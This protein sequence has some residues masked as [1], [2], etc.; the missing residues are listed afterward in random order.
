M[1]LYQ[2][3]LERA[4]GVEHDTLQQAVQLMRSLGD[5]AGEAEALGSFVAGPRALLRFA[6]NA[7]INTDDHPVVAYH[8]P[9]ITYAPDSL[10]RDRLVALLG[11]LGVADGDWLEP[12]ADAS[13]RPR[14]AAYRQARDQFIALG[15]GV[16]PSADVRQMLQQVGGPLLAMLRTSPDFRPTYDPLLRMAGALARLDKPGAQA[17][18]TELAQLQPARQEAAEAL[19]AW[20]G[21]AR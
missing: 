4:C 9:R 14:L 3:I 5:Q 13:W 6:G 1:S 7:A 10:P 17:L 21:P 15:R 11:Q 12:P 20:A 8:A 2:S 19:R 16:Q 18:L